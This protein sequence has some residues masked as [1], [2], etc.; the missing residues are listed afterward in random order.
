VADL[1]LPYYLA[2]PTTPVT[3]GIVV[4]HEGG[5]ISQQLLR[6]CERLAAEG[7]AAI[8]PDIF[9]RTGGPGASEDYRI[10][11]GALTLEQVLG[12][13][14][15]ASDVLRSAGAQ[16]IGVTGFCMGGRYTWEAAVHGSGYDAAVGF[17]GGGI[18][19]RLGTPA[20]PTLLFFGGTDDFI[21]TEDIE[22][23]VAHHADTIVYPAAGH[24]FMRDGSDS[25]APDAAADAWPRMLA[26]FRR[27]LAA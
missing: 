4:I 22:K 2:R 15:A 5:G 24:G 23:V 11:M 1:T 13:L 10:A 26:H 12:D 6:L 8:A 20:C 27:H 7:F 19:S 17:Y 18:A 9:F 16:H 21:P 14:A 25:Y 3:A